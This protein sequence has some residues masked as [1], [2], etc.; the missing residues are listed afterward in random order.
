MDKN[1]ILIYVGIFLILIGLFLRYY[2]QILF[3]GNGFIIAGA[4][5]KIIYLFLSV[6]SKKIK[7]G[8]EI[9]FLIVG[10][11]LVVV[12]SRFKTYDF[13]LRIHPILMV[14]GVLF[15]I[16]FVALWIKKMMKSDK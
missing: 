16:I 10:L 5:S 3:L 11:I 12:G 15:K 2:F 1:K 8:Y 4:L 13:I 9:I 6:I 7:I 14:I